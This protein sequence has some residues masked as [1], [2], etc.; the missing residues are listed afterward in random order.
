VLRLTTT[1]LVSGLVALVVVVA[2]AAIEDS[3]IRTPCQMK[4]V[5]LL[6]LKTDGAEVMV[7]QRKRRATYW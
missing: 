2:L 5:H 3:E 1:E 4:M 7:V 6:I